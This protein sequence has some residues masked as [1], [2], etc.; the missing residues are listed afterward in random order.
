MLRLSAYVIVQKNNLRDKHVFNF[1]SCSETI[2]K[3]SLKSPLNYQIFVM[4]YLFKVSVY[5][6]QLVKEIKVSL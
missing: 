5:N 4:R 1:D 2:I 6:N 3:Q